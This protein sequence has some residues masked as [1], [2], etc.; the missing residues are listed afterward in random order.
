MSPRDE[1][2]AEAQRLAAGAKALIENPVF[3]DVVDAVRA[4]ILK[5]W[6]SRGAMQQAEAEADRQQ[7][8][9]LN[10]IVDEIK[11]RIKGAD[12]VAYNTRRSRDD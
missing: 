12:I 10:L 11:R 6:E 8:A 7:L 2:L 1:Q 5:R 4:T 9:A 3:A